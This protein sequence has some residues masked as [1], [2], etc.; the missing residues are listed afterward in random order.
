MQLFWI[1]HLDCDLLSSEVRVEQNASQ[2]E[3]HEGSGHLTWHLRN[4]ASIADAG[5]V[6][7]SSGGVFW[8]QLRLCNP[9]CKV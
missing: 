3:P 8:I 4:I 5:L 6:T 7:L 1:I 2:R 9:K